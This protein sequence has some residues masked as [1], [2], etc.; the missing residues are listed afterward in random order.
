MTPDSP[1][2]AVAEV[3][4]DLTAEG[5]RHINR[6]WEYTQAI[7]TVTITLAAIASAMLNVESKVIE[8]AFVA[9]ISTYYARTNH[10]K[11]GGVGIARSGTR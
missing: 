7:V 2:D 10:T 4:Q 9:I 11:V 6:I 8:F 3:E 5:Q 1:P